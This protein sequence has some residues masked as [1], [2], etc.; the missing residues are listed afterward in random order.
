M[1]DLS[2]EDRSAVAAVLVPIL[3]ATLIERLQTAPPDRKAQNGVSTRAWM[4]SVYGKQGETSIPTDYDRAKQRILTAWE[5]RLGASMRGTD[6]TWFEQEW[7]ELEAEALRLWRPDVVRLMYPA[8]EPGNRRL[9]LSDRAMGKV[10]D[11]LRE[12]VVQTFQRIQAYQRNHAHLPARFASDHLDLSGIWNPTLKLEEIKEKTKRKKVDFALYPEQ[13]ALVPGYIGFGSMIDWYSNATAFANTGKARSP[14]T[15]RAMLT[16][17]LLRQEAA[18]LLQFDLH[19]AKRLDQMRQ[20]VDLMNT[21]KAT[22]EAEK[23]AAFPLPSDEFSS[24]NLAAEV[25]ANQQQYQADAAAAATEDDNGDPAADVDMTAASPSQASVSSFGVL[26]PKVINAQRN[27][28]TRLEERIAKQQEELTKQRIILGQME[29]AVTRQ[30][31]EDD[32]R[33]PPPPSASAAVSRKR[34]SP[35]TAAAASQ[36]ASVQRQVAAYQPNI[37][38][39]YLQPIVHAAAAVAIEVDADDRSETPSSSVERPSPELMIGVISEAELPPSTPVHRQ[40]P[41][42]LKS[43]GGGGQIEQGL[44]AFAQQQPS[45]AKSRA[46]SVAPTLP[47]MGSYFF[48]SSPSVSFSFDDAVGQNPAASSSSS[49]LYAPLPILGANDLLFDS[50]AEEPTHRFSEFRRATAAASRA[51][52]STRPSVRNLPPRHPGSTA[53]SH[54]APLPALP[55][56]NDHGFN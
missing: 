20:L 41:P 44:G 51:P 55:T 52:S 17:G 56:A 38:T 24:V 27:L 30:R 9:P 8:K 37:P 11:D 21:E 10:V 6:P 29:E 12:A 35:P 14:P 1:S 19:R 22:I 32:R 26:D 49:S 53:S 45:V 42:S 16:Y 13:K 4:E 36:S 15:R 5:L 46:S 54:Y 33:M 25:L 43:A 50:N 28:I 40:G 47:P 34:K 7:A 31:A 18:A 3:S 48:P 2:S 39:A 23:L